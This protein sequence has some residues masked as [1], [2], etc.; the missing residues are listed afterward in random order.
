MIKYL[1]IVVVSVA[2]IIAG[3]S[4]YLAPDDLRQCH[5]EITGQQPCKKVGAIVTVSGGDTVARTASAIALYQQGWAPLLVFSG[6]AED[7]SGPSNAAIMERQALAAGVPKSAILI[8]QYAETTKQNAVNTQSIF[9]EKD[10]TS[11]I[12]VTS[13]Y[14]QRRASMEFH[15]RSGGKIEILNQPDSNDK[16]WSR[17]WWV[18]PRGW[19]LAI[20]EFFKTLVVYAGG[21]H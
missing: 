17:L 2:L 14:H 3:L 1:I 21:T 9:Q 7:K 15:K 13:G 16:D 8:D 5:G 10:I 6:A 18:T 19:Y 4:I 12:L 20:S 11:I